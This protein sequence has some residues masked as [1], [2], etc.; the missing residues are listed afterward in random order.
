MIPKK[1]HYCWFGGNP[2][3]PLAKKC[4][5]SWE[6]HCPDYEIIRWDESNY[7]YMKHPYMREA[8]KQKKYAFV[9]DYARMDI[10]NRCGGVYLDTDVELLKSIDS[11]LSNDFYIGFENEEYVASGLGFGAIEGHFF[12][13]EIMK[14]FDSICEREDFSFIPC[15][16]I[17]TFI[18]QNQFK[19]QKNCDFIQELDGQ[20]RVFP[21]KFFCP[22][23]FDG[24]FDI[25]EETFSI[26]HYAASWV[27]WYIQ[28][29]KS[30]FIYIKKIL[31]KGITERIVALVR[32]Y[33]KN[34]SKFSL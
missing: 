25:S 31:G 7:D 10:I 23:S 27:P 12:L 34:N 3:S 1:I 18:L 16:V 15:P 2:L 24:S 11:L 28:V 14:K 8:Y 13:Q 6:I 5:A 33:T 22:K 32:K 4:L 21:Q 26:H 20:V 17:E 19:L 30:L 9:T 29:K